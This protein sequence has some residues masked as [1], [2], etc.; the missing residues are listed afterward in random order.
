V[1]GMGSAKT[2]S[3]F[4][5]CGKALFEAADCGGL[6]LGVKYNA[7]NETFQMAREAGRG[8]DVI[9]FYPGSGAEVQLDRLRIES[10]RSR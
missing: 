5:A 1:G 4:F 10:P 8:H 6:G 9:M 3:S 2:T 7:R